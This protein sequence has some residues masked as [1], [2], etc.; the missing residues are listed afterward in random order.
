MVLL[1]QNSLFISIFNIVKKF[2][3]KIILLVFI[4]VVPLIFFN[5]FIDPLQCFRTARWYKPLYDSNERVQSACL[6]RSYSYN[7]VIVGSSH[8]ENIDPAYV[9]EI[10]GVSA[11][12]LTVAASTIYEQNRVLNLAFNS[13]QVENVIWGLDTNILY[14]EPQRVRDDIV[15]FPHYLYEPN[16]FND[17]LFLLDPYQIKHYVKMLVNNFTGKY[18]EFTDLRHLNSWEKNFVFSEERVWQA[19][20]SVKEGKMMPMQNTNEKLL[21]TDLNDLSTKNIDQNVVELIKNNP[22]THFII[23]FP[24]YGILR[25]VELYKDD[26][27]K[28]EAEWRL[29]NY[30]VSELSAFKNV[31]FFDFQ[32]A[33]E[34]T[35]NLNNYKDLTH[36]IGSVDREILADIKSGR[37]QLKNGEDFDSSGELLKQIENFISSNPEKQF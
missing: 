4:T 16:F 6:A 25:F 21:V 9:D 29:K 12:R 2:F 17:L 10:Y 15:P 14:D 11:V 7:T 33:K 20:Q 19:Y 31:S 22:G 23:Y 8:V 30:L 1:V 36:Y 34:I 13:R 27:V 24:P 32:V 5:Y 28:L 37:Y 35:H 3:N 26:R 18:N